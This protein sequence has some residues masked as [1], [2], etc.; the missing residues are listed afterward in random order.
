MITEDIPYI[1]TRTLFDISSDLEKLAELLDEWDE[2]DEGQQQLLE[3][4]F[5]QLSSER[6][7]KLDGYAA[8]LSELAARAEARR[9]EAE[10]LVKL[11]QTDENRTKLL[12]ER[13]KTFFVEHDLKAVQTERYNLRLAKNG[14][15]APV[16]VDKLI[17]YTKIDPRFCLTSIDLNKEAIREALTNGEKLEWARLKERGSTIRIG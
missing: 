6:D 5:E 10:R 7:C 4:W 17:D 16:V 15:V 1:P 2:G 12:K 8:Y 9:K 13:L 11:A 14:G 3:Q